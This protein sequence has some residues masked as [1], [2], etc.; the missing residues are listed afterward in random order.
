MEFKSETELA[1]LAKTLL[2]KT[3]GKE[4]DEH[5]FIHALK[6]GYYQGWDDHVNLLKNKYNTRPLN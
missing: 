1:N 6:L 2:S 3:K 4:M 5:T